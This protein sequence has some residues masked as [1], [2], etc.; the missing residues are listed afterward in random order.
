MT[1]Q[2]LEREDCMSDSTFIPRIPQQVP[3]MQPVIVPV[4]RGS[5]PKPG[6]T[7]KPVSASKPEREKNSESVP[8][9]VNE[10]KSETMPNAGSKQET[11][12]SWLRDSAVTGVKGLPKMWK[13]LVIQLGVILIINLVFWQLKLWTLPSAL[14]SI[15]SIIIFLT[16]TYNNVIPKTIYWIIIFTFGKKLAL[17]IKGEG[18]SKAVSPMKSIVP[19]FQ[20]AL[21]AVVNSVWGLLLVGGG[22]GLIIANNFASYSRFSGARNK[23][24]KYFIAIVISFAVSYALGEC[25]KNGIF[26]FLRLFIQD[27]SYLFKKQVAYTDDHTYLLLSG[28]VAGL[29]LDAPIILMKIMYGG[30][31][32]GILLLIAGVAM[33]ILQKAKVKQ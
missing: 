27:V 8:K 22:I 7:S 24:D 12:F 29:L 1:K 33:L 6:F 9:H 25:K 16:A 19:E 18:F 3:H 20:N 2:D 31:V 13:M 15:S 23:M 17:K 26:K 5:V 28:F 30:Y 10:L 14:K 21:Q 4:L 11:L 32:L